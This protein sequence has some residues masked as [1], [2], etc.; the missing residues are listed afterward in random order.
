MSCSKIEM[1]GDSMLTPGQRLCGI[2][3]IKAFADHIQGGGP[4]NER[5]MS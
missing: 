5:I 3:H 1:T 2:A 4:K